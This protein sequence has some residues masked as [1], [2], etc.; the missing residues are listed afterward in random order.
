[1]SKKKRADLILIV[2]MLAIA[3]ILF[4]FRYFTRSTGAV[5]AIYV[6]GRRIAEYSLSEDRE[7]LL[8]SQGG[9]YNVLVIKNG[10]ADITDADC[11]DR[12]C[13]DSPSIKYNGESITCLPNKTQIVIEG[14]ESGVDL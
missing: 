6:D 7:I 5:A 3:C 8:N 14:G 4:A 11:P 1:M 2:S 9:G 12:I 13:V 10:Q